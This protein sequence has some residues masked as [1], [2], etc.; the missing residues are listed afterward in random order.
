MDLEIDDKFML[1]GL[2]YQVERKRGNRIGAKLISDE[3][4]LPIPPS[5][6]LIGNTYYNLLYANKGQKFITITK[7]Y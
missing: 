3:G 2:E 4:E 5:K 7:I 1:N 6:V